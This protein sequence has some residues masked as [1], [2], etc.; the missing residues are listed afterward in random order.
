MSWWL[1]LAVKESKLDLHPKRLYDCLWVSLCL[2]QS[3]SYCLAFTH[4]VYPALNLNVWQPVSLISSRPQPFI[5]SCPSNLQNRPVPWYQ[6]KKKIL[7]FPP[8]DGPLRRLCPWSCLEAVQEVKILSA[9]NCS[10]YQI[11]YAEHLYQPGF[12]L[13]PGFPFDSPEAQFRGINSLNTWTW[14]ANIPS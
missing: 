8:H 1:G 5:Y 9:L 7:S 6:L 4:T 2:Y 12:Q 10:H 13:R 11:Y 3:Y 14:N